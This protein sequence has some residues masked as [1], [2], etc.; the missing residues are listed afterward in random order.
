MYYDGMCPADPAGP[1]GHTWPDAFLTAMGQIMYY[2][3]WPRTGTGSYSYTDAKY[4]LQSA[5]FGAT[6]LQLGKHA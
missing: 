5:D 4:G 6:T 1:G 3:R 2:Y